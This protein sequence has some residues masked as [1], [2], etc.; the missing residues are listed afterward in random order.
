MPDQSTW[1]NLRSIPNRKL[2]LTFS[3]LLYEYRNL[4][5][6]L[7]DGIKYSRAVAARYDHIPDKDEANVK[8]AALHVWL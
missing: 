4:I 3:S 1:V 7:F 8:L 5:K 6:R 2:V